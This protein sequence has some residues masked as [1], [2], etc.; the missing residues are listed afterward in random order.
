M[1]WIPVPK[2]GFIEVSATKVSSPGILNGFSILRP[3]SISPEKLS[4][5]LNSPSFS[6]VRT[7]NSCSLFSARI[8]YSF[9][10]L[11]SKYC[12]FGLNDTA[13]APAI[14]HASS[15]KTKSLTSG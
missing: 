6:V 14:C 8:K 2:V 10:C 9:P 1:D 3:V 11:T 13:Y 7:V 15:V 4:K 5:V 12:S